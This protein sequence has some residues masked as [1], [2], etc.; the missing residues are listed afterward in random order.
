MEFYIE[1]SCYW[2][3]FEYTFTVPTDKNKKYEEMVWLVVNVNY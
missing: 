1:N 2:N 3:Y